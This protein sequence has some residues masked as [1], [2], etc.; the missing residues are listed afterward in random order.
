[1]HTKPLKNKAISPMLSRA[2]VFDIRK[3]IAAT[4]HLCELNGGAI[5]VLKVIKMLYLADRRALVEWHR[6]ITGDQFWSLANGPVVSRTYDLIRG[7]VGGPEMDAWRAV[8]NPRKEDSLSLK[9]KP[10]TKPLSRREKAALQDA[11]KQIEPLT[12]GQVIDLVHKLPEWKDPGKSSLPIDPETI[13]YH[14]NFGE[15]AVK[16]IEKELKAVKSDKVAL[17]AS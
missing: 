3:A 7:K 2:I 16:E 17:Q 12:T 15:S 6:P 1:M 9:S 13:F 5:D 4:G 11:H 8:F 14:E 10:N